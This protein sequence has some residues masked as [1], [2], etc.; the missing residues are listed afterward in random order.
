MTTEIRLGLDDRHKEDFIRLFCDEFPEIIVPVFG[1]VERCGLLLEHSLADDRI[2][3]AVLDEQLI[4]FAGLHYSGREWFDPSVSQLLIVMR[5]GV[6]RV[7][8]MGII[9]FKRPKSDVMHLDT[10]AVHPDYRGQGI[11][12]QLIDA[13]VAL[14]NAE[15]KRTITLEVED[16]NPRAK[17]LYERLGFSADKFSR[18]PWPWNKA[19]AFSG[20]YCM[21]KVMILSEL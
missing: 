9:L 12:T 1:S 7:M 10:L 5:M 19:F 4:G 13:I 16:I 21:S 15:G 6:F 8:T 18:L 2:I 11:G 17:L 20:S 14:A 3:T